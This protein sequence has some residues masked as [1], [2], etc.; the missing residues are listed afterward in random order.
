MSSHYRVHRAAY[1]FTA[2][3]GKCSRDR[4]VAKYD[5]QRIPSSSH[6]EAQF[7]Q[8]VVHMKPRSQY[9]QETYH[10]CTRRFINCGN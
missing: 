7:I 5:L 3:Q 10:M 4:T 2:Y 1:A 9:S 8:K 6:F